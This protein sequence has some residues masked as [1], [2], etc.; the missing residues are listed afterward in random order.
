MKIMKKFLIIL[1]LIQF[2]IL[3]F[4]QKAAYYGDYINAKGFRRME[5]HTVKVYRMY[6]KDIPYSYTTGT[7]CTIIKCQKGEVI[8]WFLNLRIDEGRI[9]IAEDAPLYFGYPN[10]DNL[11][12]TIVKMKAI[13]GTTGLVRGESC[14]LLYSTTEED[15]IKLCTSDKLKQILIYTSNGNIGVVLK[16]S[17]QKNLKKQLDFIN[18]LSTEECHNKYKALW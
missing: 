14:E 1:F 17:F 7:D 18:Q 2:P 9:H 11:C 8:Y 15:L 4:A 13:E 6:H 12:E 3:I 16:K 10:S 5:S